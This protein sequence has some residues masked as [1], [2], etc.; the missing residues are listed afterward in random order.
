MTPLLLREAIRSGRA[1]AIVDVRSK[2]E[3]LRGHVPGAVHIPFTSIGT[4][5]DQVPAGRDE[6]LIVYCGHGPRAWMAGAALRRHGF[7]R[8]EY[9]K[10]HMA[11]WRHL[12][13]PEERGRRSGGT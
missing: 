2:A 11:A 7:R 3:Y 4:R 8:V 12:A 10:G 9:L 5:I 1:P 13:L 6:P